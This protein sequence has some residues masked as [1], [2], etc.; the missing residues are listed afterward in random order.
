MNQT[1]TLSEQEII[2]AGL[3]EPKTEGEQV[4]ASYVESDCHYWKDVKLEPFSSRRQMAAKCLG[5][6]FDSLNEMEFQSA[7]AGLGYPDL[8]QDVC[9]VLYLCY[10]RGATNP[11]TG[12]SR[13]TDESF[14]ACNPG[15]REN[16]RRRMMDWTEQEGLEICSPTLAEASKIVTKILTEEIINRFRLPKATGAQPKGN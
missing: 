1:E 13:S 7:L 12:M 11:A 6:R 2:D 5:L 4:E 8:M 3:M 10:P 14:A 16:V 15:Q 9:I